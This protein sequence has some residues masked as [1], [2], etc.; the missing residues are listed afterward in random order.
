MKDRNFF[1]SQQDIAEHFGVNRTTI[2][3]WTKQG[4][5]Y[6]EAD[7]GKP[8]GYHIGHVLWWSMGK[9]RFEEI[10]FRG[11]TS[12]LE[13]IMFARL[14][15][16][17]LDGPY[18]EEFERRFDDSLLVYGYTPE[19]VSMARNKMAGFRAGWS[20]KVAARRNRNPAA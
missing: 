19:D 17:E 18:G 2:R 11:D 16:S 3:T 1:V 10:E 20:H 7:R 4:M 14:I 12:A 9:R 15:S 13:K 8:G 6:L 5:P